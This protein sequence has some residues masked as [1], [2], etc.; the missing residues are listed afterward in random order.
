MSDVVQ[1]HLEAQSSCLLDLAA[2]GCLPQ[3]SEMT[4]GTLSTYSM[5]MH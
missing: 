3:E 5:Y 4:S 1:A 2:L